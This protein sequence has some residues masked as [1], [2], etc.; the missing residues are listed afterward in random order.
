MR[1]L[2]IGLFALTLVASSAPTALA[3]RGLRLDADD[4]AGPLDIRSIA[5]AHDDRGRLVH[6]IRTFGTWRIGSLP[7]KDDTYLGFLFESPS[8]RFG[9]DRFVWV[10][11]S[12][13]GGLYA[14][15]YRVL[16][17]P[18]GEFLRR[19]P[20]WRPNKSSVRIAIRP[21]FL[22]SGFA[23]GYRWRATTSY[24]KGT[25]GPCRRDQEASSFPIGRCTDAAPGHQQRGLHH[26]L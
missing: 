19:V 7:A 9:S 25:A 22:G 14:E 17:H 18:N 13:T 24:E 15:L 8:D 3:D 23:N 11:R 21:R 16:T 26:D 5:H 4:T 2:L 12:E 1:R 10:R 20:V 6:T